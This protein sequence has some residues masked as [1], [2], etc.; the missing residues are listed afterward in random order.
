VPRPPEYC[1]AIAARACDFPRS[2]GLVLAPGWHSRVIPLQD[3]N[4][5]RPSRLRSGIWR[6]GATG[7]TSTTEDDPMSFLTPEELA[8]LMPAEMLPHTTPIPHRSSRATSTSRRP[9][10][11]A[12]QV[13]R[14][15]SI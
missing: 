13:K 12:R 14:G 9:R 11:E 3:G 8:Q 7:A 15:C 2:P 5:V 6:R 4:G 10:G 1:R